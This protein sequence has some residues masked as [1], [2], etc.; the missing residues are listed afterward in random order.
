MTKKIV[1]T[2][3]S[4]KKRSKFCVPAL[5]LAGDM[6]SRLMHHTIKIPTPIVKYAVATEFSILTFNK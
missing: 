6:S 1:V 5:G 2:A 3:P 4:G